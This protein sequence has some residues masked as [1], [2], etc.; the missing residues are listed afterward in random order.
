MVYGHK[1][2]TT[3]GKEN[4]FVEGCIY[5]QMSTS[6]SHQPECPYKKN[7]DEQKKKKITD[8]EQT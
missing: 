6:G 2:T 3:S 8:N 5:C 1:Y 4:F 7:L